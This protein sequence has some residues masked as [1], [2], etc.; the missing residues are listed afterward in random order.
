MVRIPASWKLEMLTDEAINKDLPA[1]ENIRKARKVRMETGKM[2][3]D[4]TRLVEVWDEKNQTLLRLLTNHTRWTAATI[5]EL[6]R[7]RWQ[8]ESFFKQ[9]KQHLRIKSFVG[10]SENALRIQTWTALIT[11]LII[12]YLKAQAKF[13]WHTSNLIGFIRLNLFVKI[14][15]LKWL[16]E[17]FFS[18]QRKP[19]KS[20]QIPLPF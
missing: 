8:I 12:Q 2:L 15:L 13:D 18:P 20:T 11:I 1:N 9:I 3:P 19:P 6:Y 17:P 4:G 16:N 14:S 5:G 10:T 7:C